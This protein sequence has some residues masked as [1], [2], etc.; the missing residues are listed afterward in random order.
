MV[1]AAAIQIEAVLGDIP[2][3][4]ATCERLADEAGRAGAEIIALPEFFT[5]GIGFVDRLA[6]A[7]LP[8]DGKATDLLCRLAARHK[9]LVGGSFLCRDNDGHVRNAYLLADPTGVVGRHDKDLPSMWENAFYIGSEDDGVLAVDEHD[10]GIAICWETMRTKTVR[11][12]RGRVDLVMVGSGWPSMPD[13]QPAPVFRRL[14]RR[15]ATNARDAMPAFARHVG[16]PLV[17]AGHAGQLRCRMPWAPIE[18]RGHFEPA[19][20]IADAHGTIIAARR[21]E[22][23]EGIVLGEIALGRVTPELQP[24]AKFWLHPLGTAATFAWHYQRWH[25]QRWYRKNVLPRPAR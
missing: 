10:V 23:G 3:N 4:L 13:W 21:P 18:Y 17:H 25:G 7:S 19:T 8:P 1:L 14:G 22:E 20:M 11:R 12:L 2:H 15:H 9:A 16:A 6:Q 24:P 5:T